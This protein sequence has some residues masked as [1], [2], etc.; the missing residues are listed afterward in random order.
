MLPSIATRPRYSTVCNLIPNCFNRSWFYHS[1]KIFIIRNERGRNGAYSNS[2]KMG[3]T[4]GTVRE[5]RMLMERVVEDRGI[6]RLLSNLPPLILAIPNGKSSL[7]LALSMPAMK[8]TAQRVNRPAKGYHL[9]SQVK[10]LHQDKITKKYIGNDFRLCN[11]ITE[12]L[13]RI[14]PFGSL[15]LIQLLCTPPPA[16]P[17]PA[18]GPSLFQSIA[19]TCKCKPGYHFPPAFFFRLRFS[20]RFHP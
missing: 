14:R 5:R 8:I 13:Y 18:S 1:A 11:M 4:A 7:L 19:S 20:A 6:P 3:I 12:Q 9:P 15:A 17:S 10:L 2:T 16:H